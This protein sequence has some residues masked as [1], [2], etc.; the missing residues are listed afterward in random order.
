MTAFRKLLLPTNF[1]DVAAHA[2][3]FARTLVDEYGGTLYVLHVHQPAVVPATPDV[4][5]GMLVL[6]PDDADVRRS[7]S[8]FV[9]STLGSLRV[10]V[11]TEMRMGSPA[12][13][14]CDYAHELGVDLIVLGTHARGLASRIFLGSISKHVLEHVEC[15]VLMVPR[16]A[17]IWEE[18]RGPGE[19][20]TSGRQQGAS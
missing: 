19:P 13:V 8:V 5:T 1:S 17:R 20:A 9:R 15:P 12:P 6:P 7:L 11:V 2:A 10:P 4:A 14:I 18:S 16:S 3:R